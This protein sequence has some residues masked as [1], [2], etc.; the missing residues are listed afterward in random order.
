MTVL[1]SSPFCARASRASCSNVIFFGPPAVTMPLTGAEA[2]AR[3]TA[4]ATSA[5]GIGWISASGTLTSSPTVMESVIAPAN[6][7]N[8][9]AC[10]IVYGRPDSRMIFSWATLARK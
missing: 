10:T 1:E 2:A 8:C 3:A 7:A 9:V 6:S 4:A 5:A